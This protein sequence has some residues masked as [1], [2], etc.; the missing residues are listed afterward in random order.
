[1]TN[2]TYTNLQT[3]ELLAKVTPQ[4]IILTRGATGASVWKKS[5][6]V[7]SDGKFVTDL[8]YP[9]APQVEAYLN[10]LLSPSSGWSVVRES[11]FE[12]LLQRDK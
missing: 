9:I 6:T 4:V 11:D 7:F 2:V 5:G 1:M 10:K 3:E 12:V 8:R